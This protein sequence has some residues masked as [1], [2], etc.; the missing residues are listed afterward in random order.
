MSEKTT[1]ENFQNTDLKEEEENPILRKLKRALS[2]DGDFPV[3]AK[4]VSELRSMANDEDTSIAE[5]TEI[6]IREPSLGTRVLHLVNSAYFGRAVP[7]MTVS[8]AVLQIGMR[9][10]VDLCAGLILMQKFIPAAKRGGVF[11]DNLQKSILISLITCSLGDDDDESGVAERGYLAGTFYSLG[12]LLLAFYFPQVYETAAKRAKARGHSIEQSIS[13]VLGITREELSFAVV[14]ALDIPAYY[15]DALTQAF[16][17]NEEDSDKE[18]YV[19]AR[20]L[21]AANIIAEAI[22]YTPSVNEL[23]KAL[24]IVRDTCGFSSS[25]LDSLMRDLPR[26]FDNHCQFIEITSFVL[27]ECVLDYSTKNGLDDSSNED[28]NE[29]SNDQLAAYIQEIKLGL[30]SGESLS[31]LI[32]TTME[33]LAFGLHFDRVLL[34]MVDEAKTS[35]VGQMILG[36]DLELEPEEVVRYFENLD[37][38]RDPDFSAYRYGIPQFFGRPLFDDCWPFAAVPIGGQN[39]CQ[40]VLYADFLAIGA[41]DSN[42]PIE[43][44]TEAA[45]TLLAELLNKAVIANS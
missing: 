18:T 29:E 33:A 16:S 26:I 15:K 10:L 23:N 30:S 12:Y 9:N 41:N 34:L 2:S 17:Y 14:D 20:C 4:V 37:P 42:T 43:G 39:K 22:V 7:I 25:Y 19:L 21:R 24:N 31:S 28:N 1:D 44:K 3:R 36:S 40:G 38:D 45:I 5:I 6:I 11:A 13:E 35:L 27:P 32:S 8:Q